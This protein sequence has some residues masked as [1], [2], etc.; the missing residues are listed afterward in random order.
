MQ[1]GH[2]NTRSNDDDAD[3]GDDDD[4]DDDADDSYALGQIPGIISKGAS[5]DDNNDDDGPA[6]DDD[7]D[8]DDDDERYLEPVEIGVFGEEDYHPQ[9][10]QHKLARTISLLSALSFLVSE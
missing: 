7:D 3:D 5:D 1:E 2:G 8:D 4:D 10:G 9:Q 6:D